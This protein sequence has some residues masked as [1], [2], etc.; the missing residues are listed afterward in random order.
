M[1]TILAKTLLGR[2]TR[3]PQAP[4]APRD[5]LRTRQDFPKLNARTFRDVWGDR[6]F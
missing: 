3:D 5:R 1:L 2:N 4:S 6:P